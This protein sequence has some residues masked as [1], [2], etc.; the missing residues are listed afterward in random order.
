M[1][2]IP[3]ERSYRALAAVPALPRMVAGMQIARIGQ[4]MVSVAIVLFTLTTYHSARLAGLVTFVAIVPGMLVSPIAGALLDRH[5]RSRLVLVDYVMAGVAPSR[6][7]E[8]SRPTWPPVV[9]CCS[10]RGMAWSAP[11]ATRRY[12]RPGSPSQRST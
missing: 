2:P 10:T 9:A 1:S 5:G 12:A 3:P 11:G 6:S 8:G 4:S 7:W